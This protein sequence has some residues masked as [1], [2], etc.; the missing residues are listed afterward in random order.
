MF[1]Y[2]ESGI[3]AHIQATLLIDDTQYCIYGDTAYI[4]R[5][6]VQRGYGAWPDG[7]AGQQEYDGAMNRL[8]E[9]VE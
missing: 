5:A 1:L 2:H 7:D 6:W 8:R 3:D 4:I 9:V